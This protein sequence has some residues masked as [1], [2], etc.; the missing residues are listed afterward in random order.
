MC[1]FSVSPSIMRH[2]SNTVVSTTLTYASVQGG[3]DLT[4][5]SVACTDVST[6]ALRELSFQHESG[7]VSNPVCQHAQYQDSIGRVRRDIFSLL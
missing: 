2:V 1:F 6:Q 3:A 7:R 5:S 4:L